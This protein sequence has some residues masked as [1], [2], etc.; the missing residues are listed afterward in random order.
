VTGA[1]GVVAL[2]VLGAPVLVA[3]GTSVEITVG[4]IGDDMAGHGFTVH[5][6]CGDLDV[7]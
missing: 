2:T 1:S 4:S 7:V 3:P 6:T 5:T